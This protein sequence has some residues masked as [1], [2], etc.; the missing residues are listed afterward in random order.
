M[1][2]TSNNTKSENK[3]KVKNNCIYKIKIS[4]NN[5]D[6]IMGAIQKAIKHFETFSTQLDNTTADTFRICDRLKC[7]LYEKH[8]L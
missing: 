2:H 5:N 1:L 6:K 8:T 3:L 4:K 7:F